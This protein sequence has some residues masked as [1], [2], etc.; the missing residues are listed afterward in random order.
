MRNLKRALSLA[1]ASVMAMVIGVMVV[2]ASPSYKDV[3]DSDN[4]EAIEVLQAVGIMVGD[5]N[6][7]FNPDANVTRTEMAVIMC[8]LLK[9]DYDHYRGIN[10]FS[11][12]PGWAASYVAACVA[13]GVTAGIGDGL[14]GGSDNVTAAQAALMIMK[15]LGYFQYAEDLE[16]DGQAAAIRQAS[17]I[18][19]FNGV[20]A[21]AEDALTRNQA[22]QLVL[23]G[24]KANMVDYTGSPGSKGTI[25]GTEI[26]VD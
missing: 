20:N 1:L 15:T 21:N 5:D 17:Y 18:G 7:G 9:L 24:L 25:D 10:N 8:R 19:L 13:D 16:P 4:I 6:G 2:G 26:D 12:V 23:N 14:Y 3:K 22:A 11:D